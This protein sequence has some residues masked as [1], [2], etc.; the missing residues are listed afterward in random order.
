MRILKSMTHIRVVVL[1]VLFA[2]PLVIA[3]SPE[4][5][6]EPLSLEHA[7]SLVEA[8]HPALRRQMAAQSRAEA[9]LAGAEANNGVSVSIEGRARWVQP[10]DIAADDDVTD[11]HKLSLF[12]RK[13][14]YDFGLTEAQRKAARQGRLGSD[15]RYQAALQQ[16]RVEVMSAFFD[17]LL[18]DLQNGRDLEELATA[19]IELD[20]VRDRQEMGQASDI[21]VLELE[22]NYEAVRTRLNLSQARQ[23]ATRAR[24]ANILDRPGMLPSNLLRP[25]LDYHKR[26][27]PEY[28]KLVELVLEENPQLLALQADLQAAQKRVEAARA[29]GS[30]RIDG[31]LEASSYSRELGSS[32][33]WRAGIYLEMPLYTGGRVDAEVARRQSEVYEIQASLDEARYTLRQQVLDAWLE[34]R[35]LSLKRERAYA[36][37][38]YRELYLDR[39]RANYEM[40]FKAD[41]GDAMVRLT[42]A[43]LETARNEYEFA[44]AW[45]QL[46]VLTGGKMPSDE[47]ETPAEGEE[48]N[49]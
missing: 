31:E 48:R 36:E 2:P 4:P 14:L 32:D 6:P 25:D 26:E 7:L 3:E 12:V 11:D 30:P 5:L 40:E 41:L 44:I 19:F 46:L 16:R 47:A 38:D 34:L 28:E 1:L 29:T 13:P 24:L 17:V 8:E 20:R 35:S 21:Q 10:A 22:S 33:R 39:S 37:Q 27:L 45:E 49:G 15:Q 42:E 9:E 18:A 43:Q 23:R